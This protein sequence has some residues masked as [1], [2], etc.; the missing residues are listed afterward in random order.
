MKTTTHYTPQY[1]D[2]LL[3]QPSLQKVFFDL[4]EPTSPSH[5]NMERHS[6]HGLLT[7]LYK[8][9][10]EIEMSSL[11][12]ITFFSCSCSGALFSLQPRSVQTQAQGRA[13][14]RG[15]SHREWASQC[16]RT[17]REPTMQP[18]QSHIY[19]HRTGNHG[20]Q[21]SWDGH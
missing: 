21:A 7:S 6:G 4:R 15:E 2:A 1:S 10:E 17:N 13:T 20:E 12:V 19:G 11:T 3:P 18:R 16:T 5:R 9:L 8:M 14:S